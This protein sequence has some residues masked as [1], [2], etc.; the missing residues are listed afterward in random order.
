MI[1]VNFKTYPQGTGIKAVELAKVLYEYAKEKGI[2][3]IAA[4]QASDIKE[5]SMIGIPTWGQHIDPLEFGAHTGATL[6]QAIKEDG[7]EGTFLNHSEKRFGSFTDLQKANE[8]AKHN[9]LQTLIFAGDADQL[10]SVISLKPDYVSYEPPELVGSTNETVATAHPDVIAKAAEI[11]KKHDIPLIV[12]AG[13]HSKQ[14]VE[15]SV[16]L[17]AAGVAVSTDIVK[18]DNPAAELMELI[19]GFK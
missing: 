6:A 15:T 5:I 2:R 16:R 3:I 12:G 19:E 10:N 14:D 9:G 13:V 11:C 8:I 1:F 7:A 4:V 18:A 17:G